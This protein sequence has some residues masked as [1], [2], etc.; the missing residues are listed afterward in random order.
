MMKNKIESVFNSL[1]ELDMKPSPHNVS[2]MD[3]VF[4]CLRDI[5]KEMEMI[6]NGGTENGSAADSDG[7]DNH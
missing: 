3:G 6:K 4:S 7:R 1:Q 2:I 5:Y